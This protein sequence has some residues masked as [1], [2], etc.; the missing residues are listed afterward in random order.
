MGY[1][2]VEVWTQWDAPTLLERLYAF[3]RPVILRGLIRDWPVMSADVADYLRRCD[4]GRPALTFAQ[5]E[6]GGDYFYGDGAGG[7][8]F[9]RYQ[10]RVGETLSRIA[11][12][13]APIYIQSAPV[14]DHLPEF[15]AR[16]RLD[17][18][19]LEVA[20]RIW[21]GNRS[22]TRTHFDLYYNIACLVAGHKRFTLFPPEQTP[23]LYMGPMEQT[24]SGVPVSMVDPSAPDLSRYPRFAEAMTHGV[25]AEMAPGDGLYVPYMWWHHVESDSDFNVLVNYWWN[26]AEPDLSAPMQA[27]FHALT[28]V[29]QLPEDQRAAW[30]AMFDAFVFEEGGDHLPEDRQGVLGPLDARQRAMIRQAV[31]RNLLG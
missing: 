11:G 31:G 23:N 2:S 1:P 8:N 4:N 28:M 14:A 13:S 19:G 10:A 20:P 7:V 18:K 26:R 15:A 30:K 29:R 5:D 3:R 17:L 25:V 9:R 27:F 22:V 21:V 24:V 6:G 16:N 12:A